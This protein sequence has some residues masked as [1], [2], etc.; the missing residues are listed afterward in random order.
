MKARHTFSL[1]LIGA[2]SYHNKTKLNA[3][4]D[5]GKAAHEAG[6]RNGGFNLST[7]C[8]ISIKIE[9]VLSKYI[10]NSSKVKYRLLP[11]FFLFYQIKPIIKIYNCSK[12]VINA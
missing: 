4:P 9:I 11:K 1:A 3:F 7:I 5:G 10:A 6:G 8:K 12:W 2:D